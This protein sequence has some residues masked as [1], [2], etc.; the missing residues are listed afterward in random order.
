MESKPYGSKRIFSEKPGRKSSKINYKVKQALNP[1]EIA[2]LVDKNRAIASE[3]N[4]IIADYIQNINESEYEN[5]WMELYD[6]PGYQ[7]NLLGDVKNKKG[8][9]LRSHIVYD[10]YC[11][12]CTVN[13]KDKTVK[14]YL[15][16]IRTIL[17][18]TKLGSEYIHFLDAG[19]SRRRWQ[20]QAD[21]IDENKWNNKIGNLRLLVALDNVHRSKRKSNTGHYG[22]YKWVH[23]QLGPRYYV[24]IK[25]DNKRLGGSRKDL[26]KAIELRNRILEEQKI[27]FI[28]TD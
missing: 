16:L 26:N 13:G 15:S 18:Q 12:S 10:Y 17:N 8:Y 9:I 2:L 28:K 19:R 7:I 25:N 5:H 4:D 24:A 22:I 20:I 23:P 11:V 21:H 1:E 3:M 14:V 27:K 6:L